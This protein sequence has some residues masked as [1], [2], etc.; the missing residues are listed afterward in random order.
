MGDGPQGVGGRS[1]FL[2]APAN[3]QHGLAHVPESPK[4]LIGGTGG[5][6]VVRLHEILGHESVLLVKGAAASAALVLLGFHSPL[7]RK[8]RIRDLSGN[9][10]V[11]SAW[12]FGTMPGGWPTASPV[13][14]SERR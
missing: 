6:L 7:G 11:P 3:V 13:S 12:P 8:N 2:A 10:C 14:W 4:R 5:P 1:P 9:R